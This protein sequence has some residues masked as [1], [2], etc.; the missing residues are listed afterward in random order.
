M[1][2]SDVALQI[3]VSKLS[4][5]QVAAGTPKNVATEAFKEA[6]VFMEV[7]DDYLTSHGLDGKEH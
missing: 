1:K 3:F 7:R 5:G 6:K 4:K 2:I